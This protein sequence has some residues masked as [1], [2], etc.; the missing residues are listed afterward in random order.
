MLGFHTT[1]YCQEKGTDRDS[2]VCEPGA[3]YAP[4]QAEES[5]LHGV[6]AGNLETFLARQRSASE[7]FRGLWSAS[8]VRFC[9]AASSLMAFCGFIATT[10]GGIV[11]FP[12]RANAGGFADRVAEEG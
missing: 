7:R 1:L 4:R 10:V 2:G 11:S 3:V 12:F 5:I 8:F 6:V 9:S